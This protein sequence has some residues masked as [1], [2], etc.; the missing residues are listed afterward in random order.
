VHIKP[1]RSDDFESLLKEIKAA[2]E[3]NENTAPVLVSQAYEG[4][5][6]GT[7]YVTSLRASMGGFDNNPSLREIL[8]EEGFKKFLQISADTI[9]NTQSVLFRFSPEMSN[10]PQDV[11]AAAPDFWQPKPVIATHKTKAKAAAVEP[12]AE[13]TKQ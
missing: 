10:P 6:G 1:G 9:D 5:R 11:I 4:T 12:A 7:Y 3:K 2:G 8:G 13:K